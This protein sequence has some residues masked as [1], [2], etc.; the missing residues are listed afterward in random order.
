MTVYNGNIKKQYYQYNQIYNDEISGN[1]GKEIATE[2]G[3]I[4]N[5]I[6]KVSC[7]IH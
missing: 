6:R 7:F 1:R 4:Y 3:N 2:N 5:E